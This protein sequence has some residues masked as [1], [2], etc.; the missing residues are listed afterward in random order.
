MSLPSNS[1]PSARGCRD[2]WSILE[3]TGKTK[4]IGLGENDD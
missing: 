3:L 2:L 4:K 1:S